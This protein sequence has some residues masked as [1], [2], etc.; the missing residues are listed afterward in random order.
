MNETIFNIQLTDQESSNFDSSHGIGLARI[1][2]HDPRPY[3]ERCLRWNDLPHLTGGGLF[4]NQPGRGFCP[5]RSF[6]R[7][8]THNDIGTTRQSDIKRLRK[9]GQLG[10]GSTKLGP[11]EPIDN[12]GP[13]ITGTSRMKRVATS[14]SV[15]QTTRWSWWHGH[16]LV[17]VFSARASFVVDSNCFF[18]PARSYFHSYIAFHFALT[19]QSIGL[20]VSFRCFCLFFYLPCFVNQTVI[21]LVLFNYSQY[22]S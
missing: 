10:G 11:W 15:N 7:I 16:H 13:S 18:S 22:C 17:K 19:I 21:H 4:D 8:A 9:T 2:G 3:Y 6:L 14:R 20:D 1:T 12:H 5:C